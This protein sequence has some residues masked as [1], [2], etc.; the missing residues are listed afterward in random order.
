MT[1]TS[2]GLKAGVQ[3][4]QGNEDPDREEH[5]WLVTLNQMQPDLDTGPYPCTT[6]GGAVH[7]HHGPEGPRRRGADMCMCPETPAGTK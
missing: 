4:P 3:L 7:V 6:A 2:G 1:R 5:T